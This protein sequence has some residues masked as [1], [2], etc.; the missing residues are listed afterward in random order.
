[1]PFPR[2]NLPENLHFHLL[3]FLSFIIFLVFLYKWLFFARKHELPLPP[4]PPKLPIIGHLHQL[5]KFPH[6]SLRSLSNKY[7]ELMLLHLGNKPTLV[8][9]SATAAEE[10]MK[11]HDL[12]FANRP[13]LRFIN[14]I[15]YDGNDIGFSSYREKWRRLKRICIMHLLSNKR[16]QSFQTIRKE[17]VD[18][19]VEKIESYDGSVFNL[20][21]ALITFS[22]GLICRTALGSK[23]SGGDDD[24]GRGTEFYQLFKLL[25]EVMGAVSLGDYIPYLG[26]ID[27]LTGL[28]HRVE[29]V[30]KKLDAFIEEVLEEHTIR[31]NAN[32]QKSQNDVQ[33]FVDVLLEVQEDNPEEISRESIK[34]ILLDMFVA[35]TETSSTTLEWAIT[36]LIRHPKIM[37]KLQEEVRNNVKYSTS[38]AEDDLGNMKYLKAVIKETL[39]LH[40]PAPLLVFR[41]SSEDV[42]IDKYGIA[43]RTQVIINA[44]TIQRDPTFWQNPENFSPDRFLNDSSS[45]D[46]KGQH[47][48]FI[49]FGAGRRMCPGVSYGIVTT[50]FLLASL[51]YRFNWTLPNGRKGETLDMEESAGITVGR[52]NPLMVIATPFDT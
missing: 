36:E 24:S 48:Q 17:I 28:E 10:I 21:E 8:V 7:G 38:V 27:R 4:S 46:Y 11:T 49:P 50:E 18:Q 12:I 1:M 9:S 51:V 52:R 16:V 15:F 40:P 41:E 5:G 26:W 30:R 29:I 39:R 23:Y 31:L 33:D 32:C 47:F 45:V 22:K 44:W 25:V 2:I 19:V 34:G 43:K 20:S 37:K 35:G 14:R 42:K 13:K 3:S 6:R